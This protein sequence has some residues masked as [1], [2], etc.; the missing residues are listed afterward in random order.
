VV[1]KFVWDKEEEH[2]DGRLFNQ[3][4]RY[5]QPTEIVFRA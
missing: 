4:D 1:L 3:D 5:S 2:V